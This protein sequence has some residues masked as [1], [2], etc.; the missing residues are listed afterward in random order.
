MQ[1]VLSVVWETVL[2][3]QNMKLL[4][5]FNVDFSIMDE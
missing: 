2:I 3:M 4:S 1:S 5:T